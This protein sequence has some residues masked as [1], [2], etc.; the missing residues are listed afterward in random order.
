MA[1]QK[2]R[3]ER[4]SEES[5]PGPILNAVINDLSS[6]DEEEFSYR[7]PCSCKWIMVVDDNSFNI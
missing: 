2:K 4:L 3:F 7:K 1:F 6:S 5:V